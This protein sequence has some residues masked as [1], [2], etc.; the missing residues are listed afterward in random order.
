MHIALKRSGSRTV[1]RS[2]GGRQTLADASVS[3]VPAVWA[4]AALSLL[5]GWSHMAY[6]GTHFHQWWAYGVFFAAA[7]AGQAAFA[8]VLLRWPRASVALIAIVGNLAIIMMYVIS[9]TVGVPLG[10][11]A[12]VVEYGSAPDLLTTAAE[13]V[14]VCVLLALVEART[15]RLVMGMLVVATLALAAM[16]L[17]GHLA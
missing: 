9:R 11:D 4:A 2:G 14:L 6:L 1:L 5:A 7:G 17:T 16:R 10:P 8:A 15:R 12:H 3:W 13:V